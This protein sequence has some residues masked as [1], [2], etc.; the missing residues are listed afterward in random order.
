MAIAK[1]LLQLFLVALILISCQSKSTNDRKLIYIGTNNNDPSKGIA[2]TFFNEATGELSQP[3]YTGNLAGANFFDPD[4]INNRLF[5]VGT[6]INPIDSSET[7]SVVTFNVDKESGKLEQI[8]NEFVHGAGPCFVE[9]NRENNKI[10][11]A[12]YSSGNTSSFDYINN[13][14]TIDRTQQHYEHGPDQDRQE[15]PHA[16]S[17]RT[18]PNSNIV[19]SAD[20]GADKIMV[21]QFVNSELQKIDSIACFPGAGPR[22]IDFSPKGDIMAVVN[23]LNCT[24][25][26]YKKDSLGIFSEEIKTSPMLPEN[27]EGFAKAA[28]IHFSPD[29]NFLYASNRGFHSIVV[30]KVNDGNIEL[31]QTFT[32][33]INWPRNFTISNDGD[34]VLVANRDSNNISVLKRDQQTGKLTFLNNN[35]N[36]ESP[37]CVRFF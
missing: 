18:E 31:V 20:L 9:Y 13:K 12:N 1:K 34:F 4:N 6:I 14:I 27:F 11:V 10:L 32:E 3:T 37:V 21:Y 36:I 24:V 15:A 28:D 35:T 19:Y 26:T 29:G 2:Y 22:H 17:I 7:Q 5:F 33:S 16:H 8:A 23:E 30:Y 25:T